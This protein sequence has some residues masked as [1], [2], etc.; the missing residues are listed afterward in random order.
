MKENTKSRTKPK[1]FRTIFINESISLAKKLSSNSKLGGI[2]QLTTFFVCMIFSMTQIKKISTWAESHITLLGLF[3]FFSLTVKPIMIATVVL[4]YKLERYETIEHE[5]VKKIAKMITKDILIFFYKEKEFIIYPLKFLVFKTFLLNQKI[6]AGIAESLLIRSILI[7]WILLDSFFSL[8]FVL[9]KVTFLRR[10]KPNSDF[11]CKLRGRFENYFLTLLPA[12]VALFSIGR[13]NYEDNFMIRNFIFGVCLVLFSFVCYNYFD[14]HPYLNKF[15]ENIV[16][17]LLVNFTMYFLIYGTYAQYNS[18]LAFEI[19]I[20]MSPV[21]IISCFKLT[22]RQYREDYLSK[23]HISKLKYLKKIYVTGHKFTNEKDFIEDYGVIQKRIISRDNNKR[24][25]SIWRLFSKL[26]NKQKMSKDYKVSSSKLLGYSKLNKQESSQ[27]SHSNRHITESK[28]VLDTEEEEYDYQG[29]FKK[30]DSFV[31]DGYIEDTGRSSYSIFLKIMWMLR[32]DIILTKV[33]ESLSELR[34][35]TTTL[36]DAYFYE[37]AKTEVCHI[38]KGIYFQ[39]NLYF[40]NINLNEEKKN[41]EFKENFKQLTDIGIDV[42]YGLQYKDR[43]SEIIHLI[44]EFITFNNKYLDLLEN[45]KKK[46]KQMNDLIKEMYQRDKIIRRKFH[47]VEKRSKSNECIHL[48]PYFYYLYKCV[49]L[50]RSASLIFKAHKS[51]TLN[52]NRFI[53]HNK[54]FFTQENFF[55]NMIIFLISANKSN[56]G[57]ILD[58]YGDAS[59]LRMKHEQLAGKH[60]NSLI[61]DSHII[62]HNIACKRF[63]ELPLTQ[64]LGSIADSYIR[65]PKTDFI[66]SVTFN[67]KIVPFVNNN[68]EFIIG[69]KFH[70]QDGNMYMLLDNK[71]NIDSFSVNM[72][73]LFDK[74]EDY[75]DKKRVKISD[76][77]E[78]LWVKMKTLIKTCRINSHKRSPIILEGSKDLSSMESEIR[79]DPEDIT[80][81]CTAVNQE[82]ELGN[83]RLRFRNLENG[84]VVKRKFFARL[85]RLKY[86]E[87]DFY[88][89]VLTL[90]YCDDF[91]WRT[92]KSVILGYYDESDFTVEKDSP[93]K[94]HVKKDEDFSDKI[95]ENVPHHALNT[96]VYHFIKDRNGK[97]QHSIEDEIKEEA[98]LEKDKKSILVVGGR[99]QKR[100]GDKESTGHNDDSSNQKNIKKVSMK[101]FP[102]SKF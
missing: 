55:D 84:S 89:Y 75:L 83:F 3:L 38:F 43:I 97:K 15:T 74:H 6:Q 102:K 44:D 40:N 56:F 31:F 76:F 58:S 90:V 4:L 59:Y 22:Q 71:F 68:F 62:P 52:Q 69:T 28:S 42:H 79:L 65:I 46:L 16:G 80:D 61:M 57:V 19:H 96:S 21:V 47:E 82:Y 67:R 78:K 85:K 87:Q 91:E 35:K 33:Y 1:D 13:L 72:A 99:Y 20:I 12:G 8:V 77:S 50:Q 64:I 100:I 41:Y 2:F 11:Y 94:R 88:Y 29:I 93:L 92:R 17:Q 14:E 95:S 63:M 45:D 98:L 54:K 49:N 37:Y 66:I 30:L 86:L 7:F 48:T 23:G 73:Y 25:M 18:F 51:R 39:R 10:Y 26:K 5:K 32:N 70:Q 9:T 27:N 101:E 24:Y 81:M 53:D 60:M 34:R 36:T